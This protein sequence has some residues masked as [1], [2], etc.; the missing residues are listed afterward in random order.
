MTMSLAGAG[1]ERDIQSNCHGVLSLVIDL[2][3]YEIC[4]DYATVRLVVITINDKCRQ[5][6]KIKII[7]A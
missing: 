3:K 7:L 1:T 5:R 6:I 2:H 4:V